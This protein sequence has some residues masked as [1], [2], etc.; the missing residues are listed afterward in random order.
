MNREMLSILRS[1]LT[2]VTSDYERKFLEEHFELE[3]LVTIPFFYSKKPLDDKAQF[4]RK[5]QEKQFFEIR[6]HFV[7]LGNFQ[8][9]ANHVGRR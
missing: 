1:D 3:N 4:L 2:I 6:K 7:W 8:H 9:F 5:M